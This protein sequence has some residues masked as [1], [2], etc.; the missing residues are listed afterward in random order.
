MNDTAKF[1]GARTEVGHLVERRLASLT[2]SLGANGTRAALAHLRRAVGRPPGTV[3][4][5][6]GVTIDGLASDRAGDQPTRQEHAVHAA[7]TLFAVHQQSKS[8]PM[9]VRGVGLG[10]A[11]RRLEAASP[12]F[13]SGDITPARRRLDALATAESLTE[14]LH[15]LRGVVDLLRS[16]DVPL[17]YVALAEDLLQLQR[18]GGAAAV[19]LRWAR[20]YYSAG[21]DDTT[22]DDDTPITD[23]VKTEEER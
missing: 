18:P 20:Q 2:Q 4:E 19:R 23:A 10:R 15:H 9:H 11:I 8:Q 21:S 3:P 6:W 7:M 13:G 17:D 12:G 22:P 1:L 5:V 14:V 16:K